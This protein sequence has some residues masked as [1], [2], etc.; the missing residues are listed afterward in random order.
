MSFSIELTKAGRELDQAGRVE[1]IELKAMAAVVSHSAGEGARRR[2][3]RRPDRSTVCSVRRSAFVSMA[4]GS[5]GVDRAIL[6]GSVTFVVYSAGSGIETVAPGLG[7]L[8]ESRLQGIRHVG[9]G[10]SIQVQRGREV[11]SVR[12]E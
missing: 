12:A 2:R 6:H 4:E 5:G 10:I 1:P 8:G 7:M 11:D 3:R 9:D